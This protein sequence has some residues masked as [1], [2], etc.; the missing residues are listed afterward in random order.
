M[1]YRIWKV[2]Q[3]MS[4]LALKGHFKIYASNIILL[5]YI[6]LACTFHVSDSQFQQEM[7]YRIW[8]IRY[9]WLAIKLAAMNMN[10]I[11][12][13]SCQSAPSSQPVGNHNNKPLFPIFIDQ[14]VAIKQAV[15]SNDMQYTSIPLLECI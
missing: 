5:P 2:S 15:K 4:Q 12:T 1:N 6:C 11:K 14:V 9:E 8:Y 13:L 10:S 3:I 7:N